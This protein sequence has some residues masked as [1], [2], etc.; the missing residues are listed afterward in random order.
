[1]QSSSKRKKATSVLRDNP[2]SKRNFHGWTS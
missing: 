2:L 1:L